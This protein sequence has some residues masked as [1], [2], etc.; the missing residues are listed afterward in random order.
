VQS[1]ALPEQLQ[2]RSLLFGMERFAAFPPAFLG[3][4]IGRG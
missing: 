1:Q 4:K 2:A 3:K